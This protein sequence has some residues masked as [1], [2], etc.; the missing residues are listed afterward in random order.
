MYVAFAPWA[1]GR[2]IAPALRRPWLLTRRVFSKK[3]DGG[4]KSLLEF[5]GR[6]KAGRAQF[7]D[8]GHRML[9]VTRPFGR[10]F[11]FRSRTGQPTD[12]CRQV[13]DRDALAVS[14][15]EN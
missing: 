3:L 14:D 11:D 10:V 12:H 6:N 13:V 5:A 4:L 8:G 9:H 15:I 1:I 7:V 2:R